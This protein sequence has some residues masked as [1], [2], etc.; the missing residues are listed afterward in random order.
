MGQFMILLSI[1]LYNLAGTGLTVQGNTFRSM[2][3]F[4]LMLSNIY[5]V[6]VLFLAWEYPVFHAY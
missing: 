5:F 2:P 4:L 1:L 6:L 3:I